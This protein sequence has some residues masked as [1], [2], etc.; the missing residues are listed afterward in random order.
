MDRSEE[1]KTAAPVRIQ[2]KRARGWRMPRGVIY[3]GRPSIYGN[4]YVVGRDGIKT[5]TQFNIP[6]DAEELCRCHNIPHIN[7]PNNLPGG[8]LHP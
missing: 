6:K 1:T 4:P 5:P 3:V 2:R 7:C 8:G